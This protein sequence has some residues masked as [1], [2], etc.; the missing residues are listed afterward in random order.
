[1]KKMLC[2]VVF[3]IYLSACASA[4]SDSS[5]TKI[6]YSYDDW[7]DIE[8]PPAPADVTERIT[9]HR[10]G[11]FTVILTDNNGNPLPEDTKI[12]VEL[13][14]QKF[15]FGCNFFKWNEYT[16]VQLR[17]TYRERFDD[18]FNFATL[19]FYW[20]YYEYNEDEIDVHTHSMDTALW[21]RERDITLKGHPLIWH[22]CFPYWGTDMSQTELVT[23]LKNRVQDAV[24]RFDGIINIWDVINESQISH[25]FDN[26]VGNWVESVGANS[27]V[28]TAFEWV[29]EAN[30]DG[31]YLINDYDVHDERYYEQ[32]SALIED[33]TVPDAVGVQSHMHHG[34]WSDETTL[35]VYNR[36]E[37][38]DLP[39][40]FTELTV[41]SGSLMQNYDYSYDRE[42]WKSTTE[43]EREQA[44]YLLHFY[45]LLYS[46]PEIEAITY[47]DLS[48]KGAWLGAPAGLLR[49][50]M[51]P[52]PAF[53]YLMKLIHDEWKTKHTLTTDKNGA[54]SFDG[55]YGTYTI[56]TD[57]TA[58]ICTL[59]T[60]G[61]TKNIILQ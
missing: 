9:Q 5:D 44:E 16:D 38:L 31:Y 2:I 52:K 36:L 47:W 61:V 33:G 35:A 10:K 7:Q 1:M 32:I 17:N 50:D 25:T 26:P 49:E 13:T 55:F 54:V 11:T 37:T 53:D 27:A 21:C 20:G 56:K 24:T 48:D 34:T 23:R 42:N 28:K 19:A 58:G 57:S 4:D 39:I 6:D 59:Y 8:L 18:L 41:L 30:P 14:S 40:H 29:N 60:D 45:R 3:I 46:L 15:L 22:E 51:T 43:M 12:S